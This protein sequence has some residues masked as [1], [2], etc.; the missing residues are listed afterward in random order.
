M[1]ACRAGLAEF[2]SLYVLQG[3]HVNDADWMGW[4]AGHHAALNGSYEVYD[5][6]RVGDADFDKQDN[7][8]DTPLHVAGSYGNTEFTQHLLLGG[9]DCSIQNLEGNQPSHIAARDNQL[10]ALQAICVYDKHIGRLNYQ[11]QTPLGLAKFHN[12]VEC[13]DFLE[14]HYRMVEVEGGRNEI[15]EI[16]WDRDLDQVNEDWKVVVGFLGER[17]YVNNVNGRA[18]P[19]TAKLP[20]ARCLE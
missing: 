16:W 11:H 14:K 9:A 6:L 10:T 15:G 20:I 1:W 17:E 8:G 19:G 4:T 18:L 7:Q 2:V 3:A 12:A 13:R 5:S